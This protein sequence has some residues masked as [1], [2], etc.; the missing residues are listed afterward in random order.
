[1][2]KEA[3]RMEKLCC[4]SIHVGPAPLVRAGEWS[5]PVLA[6][7]CS[8][9]QVRHLPLRGPWRLRDLFQHQCRVLGSKTDAV[10]DRIL[11]LGFAADVRNVIEI[12]FRVWRVQVDGGRKLTVFHRD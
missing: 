7:L 8:A 5:S 3:A 12:T 1:M 4:A 2:E 6:E 11:N 10:A 9:G